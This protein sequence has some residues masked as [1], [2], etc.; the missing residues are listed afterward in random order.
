MPSPL[1]SE[2]VVIVNPTTE[3]SPYGGTR[4]DWDAATRVTATGF[5]TQRGQS[6]DSPESSRT[7]DGTK[8]ALILNGDP[9]ISLQSRVE[10]RGETF[11]VVVRPKRVGMRG[12]I[13]HV[14]VV[15]MPI[16]EA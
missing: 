11:R 15:L 9:P 4:D 12:R 1:L 6:D 13:Q 14:E 10:Y 5:V 7:E 8:W 16:G 3:A 2:R